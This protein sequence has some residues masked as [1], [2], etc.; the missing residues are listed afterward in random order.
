[1]LCPH[2]SSPS[3]H[4][5][6]AWCLKTRRLALPVTSAL[7]ESI[8]HPLTL[9]VH[10][11]TIDLVSAPTHL[12]SFPLLPLLSPPCPLQA[13]SCLHMTVPYSPKPQCGSWEALHPVCTFVFWG[14][15]TLGVHAFSVRVSFL[16][17]DAA[18]MVTWVFLR[19]LSKDSR[20]RS[21][22]GEVFRRTVPATA[23]RGQK[24]PLA[25][26]LNKGSSSSS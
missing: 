15:D 10:T 6:Q 19:T 4:L 22:P 12:L 16:C 8:S 5:K 3:R 18:P 25:L 20:S 13:N 11:V 21:P 14:R 26:S 9:P 23:T 1:M 24:T 7:Q 17:L 2:P